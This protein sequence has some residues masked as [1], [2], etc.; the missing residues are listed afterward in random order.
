MKAINVTKYLSRQKKCSRSRHAP[1]RG[2]EGYGED[3]SYE[4]RLVRASKIALKDF[5]E[6]NN[7][8]RLAWLLE[9]VQ[10][11]DLNRLRGDQ[12]EKLQAEIA[13]FCLLEGRPQVG[14]GRDDLLK[15]DR[16]AT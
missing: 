1:N 10:R 5:A 16:F 2:E 4:I 8:R 12:F 11:S 6:H 9:F 14:I 15:E 3:S 7:E 13:A